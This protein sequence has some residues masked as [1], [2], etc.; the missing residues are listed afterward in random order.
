MDNPYDIHSWSKQYRQDVLHE[1]QAQRLTK[2][3]RRDR[4]AVGE[5]I[6]RAW[7]SL[8]PLLLGALEEYD[9]VTNRRP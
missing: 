4:G 1:V 7:A 8:T 5:R 9:A 2:Q 3:A 6:R